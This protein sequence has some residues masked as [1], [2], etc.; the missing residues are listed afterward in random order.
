MGPCWN[1]DEE[2]RRGRMESSRESVRWRFSI[3]GILMRKGKDEKRVRREIR[4]GDA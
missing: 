4:N 3:N 2:E 1:G